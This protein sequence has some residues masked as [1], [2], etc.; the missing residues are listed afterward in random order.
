MISLTSPKPARPWLQKEPKMTIALGLRCFDGLVLCTDS[1]EEDGVTKR[2]VD[3]MWVYEVHDDWGIA[4]ASAGEGDL[5]DS[6]TDGL[7]HILGNS[8]FDE[9]KLLSKLR[10][11]IKQVRTNYPESQFAFLAS[12]FGPPFYCQLFRVNDQSMHFG[13]VRRYQ[14]LGIGGSLASF[15]ISQ[16][17]KPSMF[18]ED[19]MRLAVFVAARV[20][21]HVQGCDG[22]TSVVTYKQGDRAFRLWQHGEIAEIENEL[23]AAT[24][25]ADL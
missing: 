19:G 17:F 15:L 14:T 22:P 7:Q 6:F 18:I 25:K 1:L 24:F 10:L 20:K 9:M 21:E 11:A 3:K 13:P 8:D 23:T 12:I 2:F 16:L 5:A 4:I